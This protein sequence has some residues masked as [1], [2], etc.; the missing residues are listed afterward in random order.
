YID[1]KDYLYA[2]SEAL[3][4]AKHEIYI[5][6]WW[7]SPEVYLRRTPAEN[8]HWRLDNILKRKAEQ[9]VLIYVVVYKEVK[10][11]LTLDSQHTKLTLQALHPNIRVQRHPDHAALLATTLQW[12]HHEKIVVVD[13]KMAF[14]GGI[15]LCFGRWDTHN[16]NLADNDPLNPK[17]EVFIGQDY[18]NPRIRDFEDVK[19]WDVCIIDKKNLARMP[20]H[21]LS[22]GMIGDAV[23]DVTRHFVDRWN[24]V[25]NV[26]SEDRDEIEELALPPKSIIKKEEFGK[27]KT[28]VL[29]SSTKWSTGFSHEK[30]IQNAYIHT[31][32]HAEHF[33]YIEN[34]TNIKKFLL[35]VFEGKPVIFPGLIFVNKA[36]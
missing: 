5:E 16:H 12:A 25:K 29:R 34:H 32:Q 7:L 17:S 11:A 4:N 10:Q 21:D 6:D 18:S 26:K 28:Q 22:I 3:E 13:R 2:V 14:I 24:F 15:D 19:V 23:N 30:S 8:E 1:G 31:I 36:S 35:A 9:G 20:W 27:M 33:I